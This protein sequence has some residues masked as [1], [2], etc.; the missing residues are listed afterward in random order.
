VILGNMGNS[1]CLCVIKPFPC[2]CVCLGGILLVLILK[3]FLLAG[4]VLLRNV[5]LGIRFRL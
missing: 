1:V 4:V 5:D 2:L 3:A